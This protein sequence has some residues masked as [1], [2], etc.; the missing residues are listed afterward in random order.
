MT[1]MNKAAKDDPCEPL[2]NQAPDEAQS[3]PSGMVTV[4]TLLANW[5]PCSWEE[6]TRAS[7]H[8][9]RAAASPRAGIFQTQSVVTRGAIAGGGA[10]MTRAIRSPTQQ[11]VRDL[12][13]QSVP[14]PAQAARQGLQAVVLGQDSARH[15]RF[16]SEAS[17]W[18]LGLRGAKSCG[19]PLESSRVDVS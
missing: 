18:N 15:R 7:R 3:E 11:T 6:G 19:I 5:G 10:D 2:Q 8:Q 13:C 9:Q 1:R 14:T 16:R 12:R 4:L 17:D